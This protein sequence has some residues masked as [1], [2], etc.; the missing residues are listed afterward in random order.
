ML[1]D[2]FSLPSG[3]LLDNTAPGHTE[4][5]SHKLQCEAGRGPWCVGQ[6]LAWLLVGQ[7][8]GLPLTFLTHLPAIPMGCGKH[9]WTPHVVRQRH[10]LAEEAMVLFMVEANRLFQEKH[11]SL[12]AVSVSMGHGWLL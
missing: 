8:T 1:C 9:G 2:H 5:T 3:H 10:T 12:H 6:Q 11:C 7:D 4:R